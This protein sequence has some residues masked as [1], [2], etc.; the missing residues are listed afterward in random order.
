MTFRKINFIFFIVSLCAWAIGGI[1]IATG[2]YKLPVI[3][4]PEFTFLVLAGVAGITF[5]SCWLHIKY[6]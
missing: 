1:L 2:V 6:S 5:L 4:N 3:Y